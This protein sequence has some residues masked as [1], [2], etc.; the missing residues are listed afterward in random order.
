VPPKRIETRPS[1]GDREPDVEAE[2]EAEVVGGEHVRRVGDGDQHGGLVE[3]ADRQRL[4]AAR[5]LLRQE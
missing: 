2:R 1:C 5:E 3:E 4:V